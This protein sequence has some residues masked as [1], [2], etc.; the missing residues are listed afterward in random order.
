[1]QSGQFDW[2]LVTLLRLYETHPPEDTTTL[3][4]V[5][6]GILKAAAVLKVV[7]GAGGVGLWW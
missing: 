2:L 5:I 1:M 7:R 4:F 6:L 3:S